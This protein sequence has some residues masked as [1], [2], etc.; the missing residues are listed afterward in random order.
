MA[1]IDDQRHRIIRRIVIRRHESTSADMILLWER[2]A[3]DLTAIIGHAGFYTLY[4]RAAHM[5]RIEHAE[6][7]TTAGTDFFYAEGLPTAANAR[8]VSRDQHR[9]ADHLHRRP[10][11]ADRR[12]VDDDHFTCG[13]GYRRRRY[14]W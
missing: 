10:D 14:C 1:T 13:L 11:P 8:P 2:L 12:S 5:A 4:G 9:I 3:C 6:L 7:P